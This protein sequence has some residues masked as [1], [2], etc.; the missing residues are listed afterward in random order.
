LYSRSWSNQFCSTERSSVLKHFAERGNPFHVDQAITH[1][2]DTPTV[3]LSELLAGESEDSNQLFDLLRSYCGSNDPNITG[4]VPKCVGNGILKWVSRLL[5]IMEKLPC[6]IEDACK[7]YSNIFDL[8]ATTVFRICAGNAG[9]ERI[10]LGVDPPRKHSTFEAPV[11]PQGAASPLF[12]FRRRSSSQNLNPKPSRPALIISANLEAELCAPVP[13]EMDGLL[14]LRDMIQKAQNNLKTIVK[15]DL[16][17]GWVSDPVP[18]QADD[19]ATFAC[20][21]ARV[22]EKR[23]AASWSCL[24][25]AAALHLASLIANKKI[26][27]GDT[28]DSAREQLEPLEAYAALFL[29]ATPTLVSLSNRIASVRSLRAKRV[30]QEVSCHSPVSRCFAVLRFSHFDIFALFLI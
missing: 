16:V 19:Q 9:S 4:M 24:F 26:V 2:G 14:N 29:K 17:D 7:V 23:Q 11:R 18:S 15:L 10:L 6:I 21:S 25:V 1:R 13:D 8:Y 5:I 3:V 28:N 20:K 27:D 22:L 30:V 12:G